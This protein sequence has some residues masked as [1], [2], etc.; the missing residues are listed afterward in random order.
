ME[1][2]EVGTAYLP[3]YILSQLYPYNTLVAIKFTSLFKFG[4]SQGTQAKRFLRLN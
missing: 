4:D 1:R 3:S 2:E